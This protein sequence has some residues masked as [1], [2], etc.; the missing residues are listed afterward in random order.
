L[1]TPE[2]DAGYTADA[3]MA[4]HIANHVRPEPAPERK[5]GLEALLEPVI[6]LAVAA[7]HTAR[8]AAL[9]ATEAQQRLVDGQSHAGSWLQPLEERA[10]SLKITAAQML[11]EAHLRSEEAE[12][13]N[14]AVRMAKH[15]ETRTP[16]VLP[17]EADVLF[18]G[19][20]KMG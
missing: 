2:Y 13:A 20:R 14:R 5:A 4:D 8:D 9:A 16:F 6:V 7:C 17:E 19:G 1:S 18:F 12:G 10:E 11:V 3:A 15:G